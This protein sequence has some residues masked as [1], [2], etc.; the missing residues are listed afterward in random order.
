[1]A[2]KDQKKK[3]KEKKT[4]KP[5]F[6]KEVRNEMDIF[7]HS[8]VVRKIQEFVNEDLSNW[9][10]RRCRRRFWASDLDED[11]KA[12]YNTTYEVL[13][14]LCELVAPFAPFISEEIY[15][16][17]TGEESVH[18]AYYPEV[19][20]ELIDEDN[21]YKMDLV[22]TLVSLGRSAREEANI[23]VRQPVG[24]I[25]VYGAKKEV[26]A[27]L[28]DLIKE[29]LNVKEVVFPDDLSKYMNFVL[30]LDFK[31]AGKILGK[32][33]KVAVAELNKCN[34][35]E[36]IDVL[37]EKGE[38]TF[39]ESGL[40]LKKE[41]VEMR[42]EAKDGFNVQKEGHLFVILDTSL[43]DELISEGYARELISKV[44]QLRK[45]SGFEVMDRI[46]MVIEC[47]DV[48]NNAIDSYDEYIK[49]EVLC[50]NIEFGKND[51]EK[52]KLNDREVIVKV[53]KI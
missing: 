17:L 20:E 31:V 18:L 41:W 9:Y 27:D 30:K 28:T 35:N 19:N 1:M 44:Q 8:R 40:T 49:K 5:G 48:I 24:T 53:N 6:L 25:L 21:E 23:K 11:K 13:K 33:V 15:R 37:D 43:N 51:G 42:T 14:G 22:R 47:D 2:K 29:E 26:M 36:V 34:A 7:E 12:V 45:N 10:I 46:N 16:K 32:D 4:R 3:T 50:D 52:I 38:I 39:S